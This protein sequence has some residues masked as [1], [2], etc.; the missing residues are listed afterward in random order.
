MKLGVCCFPDKLPLL[1][2]IGYDYMD[3]HF[4]W[5]CGLSDEAFAQKTAE[6]E[7][8]G[9]PGEAL[10]GFFGDVTLFSPDR[11]ASDEDALLAEIAAYAERGFARAA[12][13]GGRVAVIG[14]GRQ[15]NIPADYGRDR[16]EAYFTRIISVCGEAAD[17]HGMRIAVEPLST[18]ETNFLHTVREGAA[19]ARATG[20]PAV[21]TL[22]DFFH[23]RYNHDE[24]FSLPAVGD[25]LIH[26]HIARPG[27]RNAPVPGDEE[28]LRAWAEILDKCPSVERLTLE[29]IWKPDFDTA[30]RVSY[31]LLA[32]FKAL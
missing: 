26:A 25:T 6:V 1:R 3:V 9:L 2:E 16:A 20:S 19:I 31:P 23:L 29:C 4:A 10:Q 18:R 17:R 22:V 24:L 14:S 30:I 13:W 21:G 15:R 28:T 5:L 8:Y 11:C 32:P 12:A 7:K 27:D